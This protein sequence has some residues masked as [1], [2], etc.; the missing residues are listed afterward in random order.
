[1][2]KVEGENREQGFFRSMEME[3]MIINL[4]TTEGSQLG[5]NLR[6]KGN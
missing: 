5:V 6:L 1:M 2:L 4:Q 3:G